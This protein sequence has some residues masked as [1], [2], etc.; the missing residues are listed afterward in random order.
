[1]DC[2]RSAI[3]GGSKATILYRR[4]REEMPANDLEIEEAIHEGVQFD[5]LTAP[6]RIEKEGDKLRLTLVKMELGEPD[7]S[8]RRS[9]K[10]VAGSEYTVAATAVVAAIGQR[11]LPEL[12]NELGLE[13]ERN[14]AIRTDPKT[15][16]TKR[17][18][19]FACGDC[20]TGA[21]IAVRAVGN[22]RKT[23]ASV[24]QFL[25]GQAVTGEYVMFNSQM[26]PLDT[27]SENLFKDVER[28]ERIKMPAISDQERVATENEVE[29][30]FVP[31]EAAEE[32]RRCLECGCDYEA[33]CKLRQ[34]ATVY[35]ADQNYF[36]PP[37]E[38]GRRAYRLT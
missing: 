6:V 11:V 37:A 28:R 18:G 33:D 27:V 8:G 32:A 22:G 3:R 31:S 29:T 2:V 1:M 34:Y 19:I 25:R 36:G 26:G 16:R 9:P 7:A 20:Q 4:G 23:A 5:Y 10:P 24:D 13:L 30:G 38:G 35:G 14:G 21:N 12:A 17:P 15:F